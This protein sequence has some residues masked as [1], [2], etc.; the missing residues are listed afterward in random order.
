MKIRLPQSVYNT[1]SYIGIAIASISSF[2][3][4]FLFVLASLSKLEKAYI[5]IVIF[6]V[7]PVFI[8]VG[9]LIIPT[10]MYIKVRKT[11]KAGS[12]PSKDL[13]ILNFNVPSHRHGAI[14]FAI[15]TS[16]FFFLSALGSY[17]AY[18]FTESNIFCGT[19]CHQLMIPEYTAYQSSPHARVP[20]AECHVGAGASWYVKSKLSGLYQVYATISNTYPHPIP[21]PVKS[22]RPARETCEECHWPQ[23]VYGKQQR[24]EIYFLPDDKNTRWEIDM[25]MN[26]GGG[27]PA[28]G[29]KSGIHWHINPNIQIDYIATDDKRLEIPRVIL[30][31]LSTNETVI[32]NSTDKSVN[33]SVLAKSQ[34]RV[35]DC[36]DCHNRP[37]HIYSDPS[38]FINIAMA[39]GD[40]S[41]KLPG[42]KK[43]A[44]EACV[45]D[46]SNL[47]TAQNEIENKLLSFYR[48]NP[49]YNVKTDEAM[50]AQSIEGVKKYYSINIFP[51]MKVRWSEYPN[52]IGHLTT[53]GCFRCHDDQHVSENGR[54]IS[55]Q[56]DN[57]HIITTQGPVGQLQYGNGVTSLEFKHPEDIGD[58]WKES[59][60]DMCHSSQPL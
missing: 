15:A 31:N 59:N 33:D 11:K 24:R 50:L 55:K 57:C 2:M 8:I 43:A 13:P 36:I 32:Y 21:T 49:L 51:E 22:L 12:I 38:H 41:P 39:A 26:T 1:I 4:I 18:H 46:Y 29:Q 28:L 23:K 60:C 34:H 14:I 3:F 47:V 25:L 42:I 5:G 17:K 6:I 20:C 16:L 30:K 40:I 19:L 44:V 45:A 54:V 53:S 58:S 37:S 56:C 48:E 52:H 35:M 10:G 9:L 27:N 7:I